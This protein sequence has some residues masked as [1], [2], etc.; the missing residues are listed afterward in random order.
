[1][2][3]DTKKKAA[4]AVTALAILIFAA[5]LA[6]ARDFSSQLNGTTCEGK[7]YIF[8][9]KT[10]NSVEDVQAI[11]DANNCFVKEEKGGK[12]YLN[13]K[14]DSS[15]SAKKIDSKT[16]RISDAKDKSDLLDF[17]VEN[18][19]DSKNVIQDCNNHPYVC[20]F[21]I[22]ITPKGKNLKLN[23]ILSGGWRS[24]N[25]QVQKVF[26]YQNESYSYEEPTYS[27]RGENNSERYQNGSRSIHS[28]R[29]VEQENLSQLYADDGA[30]VE[31]IIRFSRSSIKKVDIYPI[32]FSKNYVDWSWWATGGTETTYINSSGANITVHTFTANGTF[33]VSHSMNVKVLLVGG[34]GAGGSYPGG[35]GGGGG[36]A[37]G[38][39]YNESYPLAAGENISVIVGDGGS[40]SSGSSNPGNNSVFGN[41]TA[42]GGG[43]GISIPASTGNMNGGS[44]GGN[45]TGAKSSGIQGHGGGNNLLGFG[46]GGGGG[47]GAGTSGCDGSN[48]PPY[49]GVC[50]GDGISNNITGVDTVY[51]GGGG[52]APFNAAATGYGGSGGGGNSGNSSAPSGFNGT[53]GLGG[54]AG[55]GANGGVGGH[56]GSGVVI[57][58]YPTLIGGPTINSTRISPS[59]SY[60]NS[61][62][63][64]YCNAT[65]SEGNVSY[66]YTWFLNGASFLNSTTT[67]NNES[68]LEINLGN[69]TRWNLSVGQNWTF[70]CIAYDSQGVSRLNSSNATIL[71][72]GIKTS[73]YIWNGSIWL[74][75]NN[76]TPLTFRC[77]NPPSICQ[78][79]NQNNDTGVRIFKIQNDEQDG[80]VG[81]SE[82][83][84]TNSTWSTANLICSST[85]KWSEG[86]NLTPANTFVTCANQNI[87]YGESAQV[88]MFLNI[89]SVPADFPRTFNITAE[90]G[91]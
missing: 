11:L 6:G 36:G 76:E 42:Y 7:A 12:T 83:L 22:K 16:Y 87:N 84:K 18:Q 28:T 86:I 64:G 61:T 32:L 47:G 2:A 74:T 39:V 13:L 60:T 67:A 65:S 73:V 69:L 10:I 75:Y 40:N 35:W 70:E 14:A 68:G 33:E 21:K 24:G 66:N 89:T 49:P 91:G 90:V 71:P 26:F 9:N 56:G 58:S 62:L 53:N 80:T 30:P 25:A 31:L 37:G 63:E 79:R 1:M 77:G 54:G 48:T 44:G 43:A 45:Y 55:G 19:I 72:R 29:F 27:F 59:T 78:P 88:Y 50:G 82:S 5:Y 51:A 57:I 4:I 81:V 34:G 17:S 20:D 8:E 38:L 85:P 3:D 15:V 46:S 52:G 23:D 41:L